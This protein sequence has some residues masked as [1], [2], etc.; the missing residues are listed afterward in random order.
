MDVAASLCLG[1]RT[2]TERVGPSDTAPAPAG[3]VP[4]PGTDTHPTRL[5]RSSRGIVF[6]PGFLAVLELR[7]GS[8]YTRGSEL[9]IVRY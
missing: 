2:G 1:F 3:T 6:S 4:G 8:V 5:L 7:R 9:H